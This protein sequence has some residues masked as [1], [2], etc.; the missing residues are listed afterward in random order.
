MHTL[1]CVYVHAHLLR[2]TRPSL[3]GASLCSSALVFIASLVFVLEII[4]VVLSYPF[5]FAISISFAVPDFIASR[6]F[7]SVRIRIVIACPS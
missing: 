4:F 3:V 7:A 2:Q 1:T 5:V 6:Y